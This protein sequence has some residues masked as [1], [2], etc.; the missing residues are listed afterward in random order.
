MSLNTFADRSS[1]NGGRRS[2]EGER[3]EVLDERGL[4][5]QILTRD[6][7]IPVA[8]NSIPTLVNMY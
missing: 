3:N 1:L 4:A 8:P 7:T 2:S 6:M 5:Y